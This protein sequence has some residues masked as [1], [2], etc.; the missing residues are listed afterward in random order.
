MTPSHPRPRSASGY[1]ALFWPTPTSTPPRPHSAICIPWLDPRT[2]GLFHLLWWIRLILIK[3]IV[4][5]CGLSQN[6]LKCHCWYLNMSFG[7]CWYLGLYLFL[8]INQTVSI[9]TDNQ[10]PI[11]VITCLQLVLIL[12]MNISILTYNQTLI[13]IIY[14]QAIFN[15]TLL[16]YNQILIT[17]LIILFT[18]CINFVFLFC[19]LNSWKP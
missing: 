2:Y 8:V 9:L 19:F 17:L 14:C 13:P 4:P 10:A 6:G 7:G 1:F 12:N 11:T 16:D 3:N 5:D 15:F 18:P